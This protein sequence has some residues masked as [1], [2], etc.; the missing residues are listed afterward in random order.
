M[1]GTFEHCF[2]KMHGI[3]Y[4]PSDCQLF[5]KGPAA[6]RSLKIRVMAIGM[7]TAGGWD[8]FITTFIGQFWVPFRLVN[9]VGT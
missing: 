3:S 4:H 7:G 8:C 2:A 1:A 6:S 9:V 5:M